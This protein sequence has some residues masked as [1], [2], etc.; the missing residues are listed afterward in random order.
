[1]TEM[2]PIIAGDQRPALTRDELG[3]L[4]RAH[5]LF[6]AGAAGGKCAKLFSGN[7]TGVDLANCKLAGSD[8]S[9][10][11]FYGANLRFANFQRANLYCTDLRNIDGRCG[12]FSHA[13]MRGTTLNGSNLSQAILDH[14]DFRAGRLAPLG[15]WGAGDVIDRNGSATGVD[16]SFC[17][18]RG[19]SLE[20]SN[21]KGANFNGAVIH[22]TK[23]R[24]ASL[25]GATF[26]R[27]A[28][29]DVDLSELRVPASALAH[30]LFPPSLEA[31]AERANL[32][33]KLQVH[34]RWVESDARAGAPAVLDDKD[35][36]PLADSIGRFKLTAISARRA[37]AV[38]VDLS[39][40]ELQGADF[41]GADLRGASFEGADL[42]GVN[43]RDACLHHAKFVAA[44]LRS[45][46]LRNG[47]LR[48]SNFTGASL[49]AEQI[50][51][52]I[53]D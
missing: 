12:D 6:L 41:E 49:S 16:F 34:Q 15:R 9:G 21:L 45:L 52:A 20:G 37:I 18:L 28:F 23:F 40:T 14:V 29:T 24:G 11:V 8:F 3:K 22:A 17:S 4:V 25:S 46:Q 35:L 36:R 13:D 27:T 1:M 44:D 32:L 19:A 2:K 5:E 38:G 47:S 33:V 30:C 48:Q 42:R 53:V 26:E 51:D 10:S 39:C 7:L 50:A 31:V 43:F